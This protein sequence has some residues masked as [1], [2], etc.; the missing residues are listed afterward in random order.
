MHSYIKLM[1]GPFLF[2]E[3]TH[4]SILGPLLL[5]LYRGQI[6]S[7]EQVVIWFFAWIKLSIVLDL[8]LIFDFR[9]ILIISEISI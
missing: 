7:Q 3:G 6:A 9:Y 2:C 8:F 5:L 1:I 4:Q